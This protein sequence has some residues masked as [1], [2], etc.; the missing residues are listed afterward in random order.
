MDT[1]AHLTQN[2]ERLSAIVSEVADLKAPKFSE[3]DLDEVIDA[4]LE[5]LQVLAAM[6]GVSIARRGSSKHRALV[7]R[8]LV[9]E[10]LLVIITNA[11]EAPRPQGRDPGLSIILSDDGGILEIA[12]QDNGTGI[13]NATPQTPLAEIPS[14]K[15]RPAEGL[16]TAQLA[17]DVSRGELRLLRTGRDGTLMTLR[18]PTGMAAVP[19]T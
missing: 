12:V 11:V 7:P 4:A 16:V 2:L 9:L 15:A 5:D 10:A 3:V 18:L 17:A 14:T 19:R 13:P 1:V 6:F 8:E